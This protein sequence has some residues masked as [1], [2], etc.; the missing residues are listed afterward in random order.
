MSKL[1]PGTFRGRDAKEKRFQ[2]WV[3]VKLDQLGVWHTSV[4]YG[5]GGDEGFP[6]MLWDARRRWPVELKVGEI[7]NGVL[8]PRDIRPAQVAWHYNHIKHG[9]NSVF[10]IGV[11]EHGAWRMFVVWAGDLDVS[12]MN[13]DE[14]MIADCGSNITTVIDIIGEG[15]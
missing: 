4:E 13:V 5:L 2:R 7:K 3:R 12:G 14:G 8:K 15:D 1:E 10:L 9:G 11:E 6:D